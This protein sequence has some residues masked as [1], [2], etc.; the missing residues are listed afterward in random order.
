MKTCKKCNVEKPLDMFS[1][2]QRGGKTYWLG[3]CKACHAFGQLEKR[4][5]RGVKKKKILFNDGAVKECGRCGERKPHADF[6]QKN[7]K[8]VSKCKVCHNLYY[9]SY[10]SQADNRDRHRAM[11]SIRKKNTPRYVMHGLT[12]EQFEA[13]KTESGLCPICEKKEQSVLDHDHSC[14]P[15][16]TSCGSCVRGYICNN[17]NAGLG[18]LGDSLETV[19]KA[20]QYLIE[21]SGLHY[22]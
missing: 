12:L 20:Y 21:N 14:C 22:K 10:Y 15:G 3:S 8:P 4:R 5:S 18:Q 6:A 2:I 16:Q 13:L 19:L 9:K 1:T 11:V 7:G 17:C